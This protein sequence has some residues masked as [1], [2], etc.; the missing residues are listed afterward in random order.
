M[1]HTQRNVSCWAHVWQH[2]ARHPQ[3]H[4][5]KGSVAEEKRS[6]LAT[7]V[8]ELKSLMAKKAAFQAELKR[9]AEEAQAEGG[10]GLEGDGSTGSCSCKVGLAT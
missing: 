4:A 10:K 7:Q 9:K 6:V 8:E 3:T 5:C 2:V 1:T